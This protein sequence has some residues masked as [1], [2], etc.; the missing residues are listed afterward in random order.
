M[1]I[2]DATVIF[3][4]MARLPPYLR[5]RFRRKASL[6][7]EE[8]AS[9][10]EVGTKP[11]QRTI[12]GEHRE[13][14]IAAGYTWGNNRA[15]FCFGSRGGCGHWAAR[16][17]RIV[18]RSSDLNSRGLIARVVM[19]LMWGI[20]GLQAPNFPVALFQRRFKPADILKQARTRKTQEIEAE[21]WILEIK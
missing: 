19:P 11:M 10:K 21:G 1:G 6:T 3:D 5:G 16:A 13:R 17:R 8:F 20:G 7:D 18:Q 2:G 9:L 4:G 12:P 15:P 14:L